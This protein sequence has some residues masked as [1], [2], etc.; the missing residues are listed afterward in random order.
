[1]LADG[2]NSHFRDKY[3]EHFAPEVDL[4]SNKFTWM[5]S[6]KPLDAFTFLFQETEW[7]P[8]IAHCLSV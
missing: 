6:T 3:I 2:I 4:R 8:F 7:G 1:V 5:G